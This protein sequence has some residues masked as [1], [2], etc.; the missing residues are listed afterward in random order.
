MESVNGSILSATGFVGGSVG[1]EDGVIVEL[2]KKK[3]ARP[4]VTGIVLP[5][6]CNAHT[7]LG[8]AFI[9]MELKGTVEELFAPPDGLKHR[10]LAKATEEEVVSGIRTAVEGMVLGGTGSFWDF[11][12]SGV[13]GARMLYKGC[14][15]NAIEPVCLGRPS[16]MKY[17]REEVRSILRTCD[18]LGVSSTRDWPYPELEKLSRDAR[19]AGK[20]FATHCSEVVREDIDKVLDLKP[21]FLVHMIA[22]TESDLE[23]C[24]DANVPIVVCPRSNAF[25]GKLPDIP[26]M[27]SKGVTLLLGTDNAMLNAPS[28]LRE[29]DFAFRAAKLKGNVS[30]ADIVSMAIRGRKGLSGLAN[31]GFQT[32]ER[33]C[34]AVLDVPAG[35]DP[36]SAVLRATEADVA[37]VWLG[38]RKWQRQERQQPELKVQRRQSD[39]RIGSRRSSLKRKSRRPRT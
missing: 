30:P 12:E 25:F 20:T 18:G 35:R 19:M 31:V 27:L 22:A 26:L 17:D 1:V 10:M 3:T 32:G 11:R 24:A 2:S 6:F 37:L 34:L 13:D 15:G 5:A 4:L 28:M 36:Y 23:R 38:E 39:R 7:H 29:I 14:L 8:D 16:A 21:D 9:R 33:A